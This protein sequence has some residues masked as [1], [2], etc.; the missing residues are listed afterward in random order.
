MLNKWWYSETRWWFSVCFTPPSVELWL[1]SASMLCTTAALFF[2]PLMRTC[3]LRHA[4]IGECCFSVSSSTFLDRTVQIHAA[5]TKFR[6]EF[7]L[8]WLQSSWSY[9]GWGRVLLYTHTE[10]IL[11]LKYANIHAVF[12]FSLSQVWHVCITKAQRQI[13]TAHLQPLFHTVSVTGYS[14]IC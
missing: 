6:P 1:P 4:C 10:T 7:E 12:I 8:L 14:A 9:S 13:T 5:A 3:W 2:L 11:N